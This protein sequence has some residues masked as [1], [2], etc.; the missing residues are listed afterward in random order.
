MLDRGSDVV[1]LD[2]RNI[3]ETRVGRFRGALD[4][5]IPTFRHFPEA[6]KKLPDDM[7]SKTIVMYCTGGIR[8]EKAS[9]VMLNSGFRDVR[10]LEEASWHIWMTLAT[11]TGRGTVLCSIR[12]SPS[13]RTWR[14]QISRCALGAESHFQ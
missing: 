4:L 6:V 10:Q 5:Q 12:E 2:T 7:K 8:C 14:N 11:H 13:M 3:Y 9:V 1:I